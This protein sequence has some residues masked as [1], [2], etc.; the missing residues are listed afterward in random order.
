MQPSPSTEPQTIVGACGGAFTERARRRGAHLFA[1]GQSALEGMSKEVALFTVQHEHNRPYRI[2]I[3]VGELETRDRLRVECQCPFFTAGHPCEHVYAALLALEAG[4]EAW[5]IIPPRALDQRLDVVPHRTGLPLGEDTFFEGEHA[6]ARLTQGE[7]NAANRQDW[8]SRFDT[9]R[10]STVTIFDTTHGYIDRLELILDPSRSETAGAPVLSARAFDP[11]EDRLAPIS[12]SR[13]D[14]DRISDPTMRAV[15][16]PWLACPPL[17]QRSGADALAPDPG[18]LVADTRRVPAG[19]QHN[20][21]T[22]LSGK[23]RFGVNGAPVTIENGPPWQLE[24]HIHRAED[25]VTADGM[26]VRENSEARALSEAQL[27][28]R[29]GW[30]FFDH[31]VAPLLPGPSFDWIRHLQREGRIEALSSSPEEFLASLVQMPTLPPIQLGPSLS[32]W[33]LTRPEPIPSIAIGTLD[34]KIRRSTTE[35]VFGYDD[36]QV[37]QQDTYSGIVVADEKR[38]LFRDFAKERS[39]LRRL[40]TAG[41][42]STI[43]NTFVVKSSVV[44]GLELKMVELGANIQREGV[45]LRKAGQSRLQLNSGPGWFELDGQ[46]DFSGMLVELNS[47]LSVVQDGS[48]RISLPDGS[49]GILSPTEVRRLR[50]LSGLGRKHEGKLRFAYSQAILL[51]ALVSDQPSVLRDETFDQTVENLRGDLVISTHKEPESFN[52][53]LRSYQQLGLGWMLV[54]K[55]LSLGGC[56]ADDMGLGKTVQV[57]ALL[58]MTHLHPEETP[59]LDQISPSTTYHCSLVVAPRSLVF[60]WR[61]EAARFIP[62]LRVVEYTGQSRTSQLEGLEKADVLVTTYGTLRRDADILATINFDFVILDEAQ[63]IKNH[64]AQVS[65]ACRALQC[66]HRLALSGTPVENDVSELWS[67]FEFLNP[68]MLG[69]R[70]DFVRLAQGDA[71]HL[72]ARGLAPLLLRRR[73]TDVLAELPEKTELT[74]YCD[75][76]SQERQ[77]YEALRARYRKEIDKKAASNGASSLRT[78]VLEALLRLRQMA[79]HAGLINDEHRTE[80]STKLETLISHLQEVVAEG[81]KALVFSQFVKLLTIV[82]TRLEAEGI[83]YAYLDGQIRDKKSVVEHFQNDSNDSCPV[84]LISLRAGGLGLNLTA[85][86]YVFILD[87]WWNP[88]VE[89]QAIDRAHRIGQTRPVFAYRYIARNTVEEKILALHKDKRAL[90]EAIMGGEGQRTG[91]LSLDELRLLLQ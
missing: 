6:F 77:Q 5:R 31:K 15:I 89:A 64:S 91:K 24:I 40:I 10:R 17:G 61:Q 1:S 63:T 85:A 57:L 7:N 65:K 3:D 52:G 83:P 4:G 29:D 84:F 75:L 14:V 36:L 54:M 22:N 33:T 19:L 44:P 41:V 28:L 38:I 13:R 50:A 60:N 76:S 49:E 90:A 9:L 59:E 47:V 71:L 62:D 48:H 8:R 23:L 80:T 86:D 37:S 70:S 42:E 67:I 20:L 45:C 66:R 82:R 11:K 53:T 51:D 35:V 72:V 27:I 87:P 21:F 2:A 34:P 79:C 58:A 73:K 30:V 74:V 26:L 55:R 43:D 81:H 78:D 18:Q 46:I 88:A 39:W 25:G 16:D 68:G 56:L 12:L 69:S 32:D